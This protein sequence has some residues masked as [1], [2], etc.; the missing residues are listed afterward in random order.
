LD[1]EKQLEALQDTHAEAQTQ[2]R[3]TTDGLQLLQI[4]KEASDARLGGVMQELSQE[5]Q[6]AAE[7]R[8]L[9]ENSQVR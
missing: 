1:V 2:L 4:E 7:T 3:T 9:L 5:R 6:A 8:A